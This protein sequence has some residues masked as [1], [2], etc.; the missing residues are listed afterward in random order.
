MPLP[1]IL[2]LALGIGVAAALA[3]GGE[4]RLSPRHALLTSAFQA[5]AGFLCLLLVPISVYFYVFH[6]DWFMLYAIDVRRVPSA[7]ALLGFLLEA[8]IGVLGFSIGAA[9]ARSQRDGAGLAVVGVCAVLSGAVVFLW[10]DRL[11]VVGTYAQFHGGF[12]LQRYG[13]LLM[14]G[15]LSMAGFLL[16]GAAFLLLR[17]RASQ[18]R[19]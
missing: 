5:F 14:Q 17:L 4:L 16:L 8:G 19:V 10:P 11:A 18:R 9:L 2:F 1:S 13:G 6:G 7:V 12:G 3:G 15:G